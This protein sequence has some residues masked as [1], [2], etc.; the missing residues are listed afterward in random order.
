MSNSIRLYTQDNCPYCVLMK[1]KLGQQLSQTQDLRI[2]V[3][4]QLDLLMELKFTLEFHLLMLR[5]QAMRL[6]Q[7]LVLRLLALRILKW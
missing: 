1:K 4:R 3:I 2:E 5:V 7:A 6:Q